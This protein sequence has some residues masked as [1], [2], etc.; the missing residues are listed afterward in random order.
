LYESLN[1]SYSVQCSLASI[2]PLL[3]SRHRLSY[4]MPTH[5]EMSVTIIKR[6]YMTRSDNFPMVCTKTDI[7][8]ACEPV[9][10]SMQAVTRSNFAH[11]LTP[12]TQYVS[13]FATILY[14]LSVGSCPSLDTATASILQ[15]CMVLLKFSTSKTFRK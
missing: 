12:A 5:S 6:Q 8:G 3:L 9:T 4:E 15:F 1:S 14:E 10:I 2:D 13:R 11:H 7:K